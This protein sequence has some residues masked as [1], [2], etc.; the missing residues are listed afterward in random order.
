MFA[1]DI[2]SSWINFQTA[3]SQH[4]HK[5][6]DEYD[7]GGL[8][9]CTWVPNSTE[10]KLDNLNT[11]LCHESWYYNR[12][13]GR[14]LTCTKCMFIGVLLCDYCDCFDIKG[15][16]VINQKKHRKD[17]PLAQ[18]RKKCCG[19]GSPPD[20]CET[21][22]V[23]SRYNKQFWY[24]CLKA[25]NQSVNTY[26]KRHVGN[27]SNKNIAFMYENRDSLYLYTTNYIIPNAPCHHSHHVMMVPF[28]NCM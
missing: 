10:Q 14:F 3:D 11:I 21:L 20:A 15:R 7:G 26:L 5:H 25:E 13:Q 17:R 18:R 4:R 2:P 1:I 23:G 22:S 27:C 19:N 28:T 8:R 9:Q 6:C 12:Q 16:S 24:P